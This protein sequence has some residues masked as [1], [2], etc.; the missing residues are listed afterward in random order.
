L[1]SPSDLL[2]DAACKKRRAPDDSWAPISFSCNAIAAS[3]ARPD[4][5]CCRAA[6]VAA[7][8]AGFPLADVIQAVG[9]KAQ[10]VADGHFAAAAPEHDYSVA[11]D[12][13]VEAAPDVHC[14]PAVPDDWAP[15]G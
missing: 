10:P 15:A 11:R 13:L 8:Q 6:D 12:F 3:S 4:V 1:A 9:S 5:S 2:P 14:A 7:A